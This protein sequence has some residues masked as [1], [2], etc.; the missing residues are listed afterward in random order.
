MKKLPYILYALLAVALAGLLIWDYMS[1]QTI[2]KDNLSRAGLLLLGLVLSVLKLNGRNGRKVANKK[3]LYA[4]AYSE[5]IQNIF[6]DDRKLEKRFY[7]AVDDYNNDNPAAGASKLEKLMGSCVSRNDRYAVT[8]FLA[9]CLGDMQLHDK[10]A[11]QYRAALAIKPNSS[12][13][14][15][16][17]LAL[18]RM[19]RDSEADAAYEQAVR[20]D[21]ANAN[22]WNNMAQKQMRSG[23]YEK[24]LELAAKAAELNPK[25]TPAH[26]A[27]AICSYML[28]DMEAYEQHYR[29]AV[30]N[31]A[32]GKR[33]KAYIEALNAEA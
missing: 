7:D 18:E 31:G 1:D 3:A 26:N 23:S 16:L 30:S 28:G 15:N 22:A 9:L 4:K 21:P 32:D 25:L 14:S 33:I 20:L 13:Y 8:V 17:A 19:G 6:P 10:A 27:L 29:R 24:A 12:L 11:E 5:Y 2:S